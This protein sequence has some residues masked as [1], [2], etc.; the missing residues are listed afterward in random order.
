V[1]S[2]DDVLEIV[3]MYKLRWHIEQYHL[4]LKSGC[5]IEKLQFETA[6]R[7]LKVI[8]ILSAVALR[9]LQITYH[10]RL[11]PAT[12]CTEILSHTEWQ[13]LQTRIQGKPVAK[14]A[15]PPTL[16]QAVLWIGRLGGHLGRKSDGMPGVRAMWSGWRDLQILTKMYI[17]CTSGL[18]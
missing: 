9:I 8:S 15:R 1:D 7:I 12:P 16:K 6:A 18:D 4:I 14:H 2:L 17:V 11:E 3:R 10:A 5:R 13:A